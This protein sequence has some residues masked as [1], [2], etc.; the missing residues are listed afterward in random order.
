MKKIVFI[1]AILFQYGLKAQAPQ[2]FSYQVV[3]RNA[4]N[5]LV[6]NQAVGIKISL[7][8]GSATGTAVYVE[9]H[10]PTTNANGLASIEIGAGTVS[11]GVFSNINWSAGT[12][13]VQSDVDPTGGTNYTITGTN[14]L[15]SVPYA[16]YAQNSSN[17]FTHFIGENYGGGIIFNLW[18]DNAG[19]EHGLIVDIK[20]LSSDVN[21]S[22]T[23][24]SSATSLFNGL[25]NTNSL[26]FSSLNVGTAPDLCLNSTSQG[27]TDWYLPSIN[28]LSQIYN[29]IFTINLSLS[30][31]SGADIIGKAGSY[32]S[33]TVENGA[34]CY[35]FNFESGLTQIESQTFQNIGKRY[36]RAIRAF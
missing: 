5:V 31:I 35:D 20:D 34:R 16:L 4:S 7:L 36:V 26:T 22:N 3:I 19:V 29:S 27:Q 30:Q 25:N 33:S 23:G 2:K 14:Q 10:T 15:L 6:T 12:Y 24:N 28:E 32:Y 18:K 8:Q 1:L 11:T 21:L 13:Y 9:T 17:G